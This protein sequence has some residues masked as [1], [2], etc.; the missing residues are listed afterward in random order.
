L[1][2]FR[3][4]SMPLEGYTLRYRSSSIWH[5]IEVLTSRPT[6]WVL[7]QL[8]C[9]HS[10]VVGELDSVCLWFFQFLAY[11]FIHEMVLQNWNHCKITDIMMWGQL[12]SRAMTLSLSIVSLLPTMSSKTTGRYFSTLTRVNGYTKAENWLYQGSS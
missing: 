8:L 1:I 9:K 7:K 5:D 12:P 6:R 11:P 2:L 4:T 10:R 3:T